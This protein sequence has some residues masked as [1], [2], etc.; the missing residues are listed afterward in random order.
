MSAILALEIDFP[1]FNRISSFYD[2]LVNYAKYT[3]Q[4]NKNWIVVFFIFYDSDKLVENQ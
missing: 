2:L 1:I 3:S 4:F